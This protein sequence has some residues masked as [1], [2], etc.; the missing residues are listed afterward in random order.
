MLLSN[1]ESLPSCS[2]LITW[3]RVEFS[4]F[5]SRFILDPSLREQVSW[6]FSFLT[7]RWGKL[8]GFCSRKRAKLNFKSVTMVTD[9]VNLIGSPGFF[10]E[11]WVSLTPPLL[12]RR[13]QLVPTSTRFLCFFSWTFPTCHLSF[14]S[15]IRSFLR[16]IFNDWSSLMTP[17]LLGKGAGAPD[18]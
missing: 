18:G 17:R 6:R 3:S 16:F 11:L 10:S 13:G 2:C 15:H 8:R 14:S 5:W 4:F 9:S 1:Y 7:P 12:S